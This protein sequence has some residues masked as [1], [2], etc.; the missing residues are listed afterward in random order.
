[1]G[2][3]GFTI[4]GSCS[5][6]KCALGSK[7]LSITVER[8][9]N[10]INDG[11]SYQEKDKCFVAVYPSIKDPKGLPDSFDMACRRLNNTEKR[12]STPPLMQTF[13]MIR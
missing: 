8:E 3:K 10:L 5:C 7:G 6:K 2:I 9:Q 1:M 12:L 4:C 13:M 11:L